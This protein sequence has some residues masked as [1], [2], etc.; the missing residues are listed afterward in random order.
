M[1]LWVLKALEMRNLLER[2]FFQVLC[3]VD[4]S[5]WQLADIKKWTRRLTENCS[6]RCLMTKSWWTL[7]PLWTFRI[8][9]KIRTPWAYQTLVELTIGKR[10][11]SDLSRKLANHNSQK[12][13][14]YSKNSSPGSTDAA[15]K[16][17]KKRIAS[18]LCRSIIIFIKR[19]WPI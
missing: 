13:F 14:Q 2:V 1:K 3:T 10:R 5:V 16:N 12:S 6:T 9:T 4:Y 11:S 17:A 15:E 19:W 7:L 18:N 8:T